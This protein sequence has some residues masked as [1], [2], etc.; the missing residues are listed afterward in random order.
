[1]L[2]TQQESNDDSGWGHCLPQSGQAVA[3]LGWFEGKNKEDSNDS[4]GVVGVEQV[5]HCFGVFGEAVLSMP[6][7]TACHLLLKL[8]GIGSTDWRQ[9]R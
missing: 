2:L 7:D 4:D 1:M 6:I 9:P 3:H 8:A 5:C